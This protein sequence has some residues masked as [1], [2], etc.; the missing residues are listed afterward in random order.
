MDRPI[1]IGQNISMKQVDISYIYNLGKEMIIS[2]YLLNEFI[3]K[4]TFFKNVKLHSKMY[5]NS[6]KIDSCNKSTSGR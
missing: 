1:C 4:D 6:Q 3:K 2:E 5:N